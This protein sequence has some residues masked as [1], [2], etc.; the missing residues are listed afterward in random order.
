MP[1]VPKLSRR[2]FIEGA[3]TATALAMAPVIH[4]AQ[5][6][7][8]TEQL[9]ELSAGEAVA[10]LSRGDMTAERYAI[11][12][13]ARCESLSA[14]N[15]F[16]T[17]DPAR[18]LEAARARDKHRSAGGKLGPMFG[19]P[20]PVK[21][22][23][24]TADY[25]TTAGTPALRHFQPTEDASIVKTLRAAGAI[26]LGKT[27]LHELSYG[28]TSNNMAFGAVHNPYDPGRIPGGSS[29]GTAAAIAAR[30]APLG[31]AE[32]TQGSIRVPAALCGISGLRPTTGRYSMKGCAPITPLFDQVGPHARS[33]ADLVLFDSVAANDW[34]PLART[35]LQGA[36]FGIARDYW[37]TGLDPEVERL[38]DQAL[39]RLRESGAQIIET[40]LPG[41]QRLIDQTTELIQ[42]HD[43]RGALGQYLA[44]YGAKLTLQQVVEQASPDIQA[45]FRSIGLPGGQYFVT[46]QAY[47]KARNVHLPALRRLYREYFARTGV[48]AVV[49]PTTMAPAPAIGEDVTVNI[50]GH[51]VSF[52]T[53][54][55]RNIAPGS[56]AGLPGLVLPAGLTSTGLPVGIEFDGPAGSDR[57]LLAVGLS[58]ERALG[59]IPAPR[60]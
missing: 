10:R 44:Q 20:I 51:D 59:A 27:N 50:G 56:T 12:L 13:L 22:S 23:V 17:L 5:P 14:L 41:L 46:E 31:V 19:L 42:N 9:T 43:V 28:W 60:I 48:A 39:Q 24:N 58:V 16:I 54:A 30:M 37:F 55:G 18:V 38:T 26:V 49:F 32:D 4:G 45:I 36:R 34:Q 57:A 25:P 53:V 35:S 52:F 11:A 29:G 47:A 7:R 1:E 21:D 33:V 8:G 2:S 40:Q 6:A 3:S 15:A